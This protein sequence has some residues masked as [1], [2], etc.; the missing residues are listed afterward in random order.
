MNVYLLKA[1]VLS[2]LLLITTN[3]YCQIEGGK[4]DQNSLP[5]YSLSLSTN[6]AT[7]LL[8]IPSLGVSYKVSDRNELLLDGSYSHWNF[9][10]Q[11]RPHY[12][13]S[14]NLSPQVRSYVNADRSTYLGVQFNVGEYN[15]SSQQG[16]YL[17]GGVTVGKQYY[18][19]KNLVIDLGLTLGY[20]RFRDR[21]SYIYQNN[22]FYR[23]RV[24]ED[25]NYWGPTSVSIK[26][27]RKIN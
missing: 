26:L 16:K 6:L 24:K 23:N 1:Y 27:A 10:R 18:A 12:W 2:V 8:G 19:G 5:K 11:G 13:R 9:Q 7:W 25:S 22:V 21:A 14:W 15:I 20:L 4:E 17:G 3:T